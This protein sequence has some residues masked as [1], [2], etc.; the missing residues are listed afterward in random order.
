M[1]SKDF[2]REA[3]NPQ[4]LQYI[5]STPGFS[6]PSTNLAVFAWDDKTLSRLIKMGLNPG[7]ELR[8]IRTPQKGQ[9]GLGIVDLSNSMGAVGAIDTDGGVFVVSSIDND[10]D[11]IDARQ[12][13]RSLSNSKVRKLFSRLEDLEDLY[14]EKKDSKKDF[15]GTIIEK[16]KKYNEDADDQVDDDLLNFTADD[17]LGIKAELRDKIDSLEDSLEN[18]R[19]Q[20]KSLKVL[21]DKEQEGSEKRKELLMKM[22]AVGEKINET[23]MN[24]DGLDAILSNDSLFKESRK[25]SKEGDSKQIQKQIEQWLDNLNS[26]FPGLD[27]EDAE[28]FIPQ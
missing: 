1:K 14:N 6:M 2:L 21:K 28:Q 20:S 9:L 24:L 12:F 3:V 13:F 17:E 15:E 5:S 8:T 16:I 18:L 23:E 25:K 10:A 27:I 11:G 22:V 19:K 4:L 7:L 26:D